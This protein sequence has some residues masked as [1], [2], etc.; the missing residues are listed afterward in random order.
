LK[1]GF[2]SIAIAAFCER[3]LQRDL[4]R[5]DSDARRRAWAG[6]L[7]CRALFR[8]TRGSSVRATFIRLCSPGSRGFLRFE[9]YRG[10]AGV[11]LLDL[12]WV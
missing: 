12:T 9:V 4:D 2:G 8:S 5:I 11:F 6:R 3:L 10:G 7:V 1:V